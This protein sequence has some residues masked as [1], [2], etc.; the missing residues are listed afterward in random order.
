MSRKVLILGA[1]YGSLLGT[2]LLM[3]GHDVTLVCR[4]ATAE[5]FN[6]EGSEVRIKLRDEDMHRAFR[7]NDLPGTLDAME[8]AEVRPE[9]YDLIVL[10]MS[11]PHMLVRMCARSC[12]G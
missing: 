7:S 6:A 8:P 3:A 9:A 12:R 5:L 10:A 1:S 2:K 4:K 11:E